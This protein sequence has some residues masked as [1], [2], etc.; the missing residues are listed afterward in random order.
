MS[1]EKVLTKEEAERV[2]AVFFED[3][4]EITLRDGKT[5][6]IPPANLKNA[7]RLM[8]LMGTINIDAII[9]NFSPS[10]DDDSQR[11][12]DLFEVL[13]IAFENYPE[14]DREYLEEYVDLITASKIIE[15]LIG[16]NGLK[17]LKPQQGAG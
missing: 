17:K 12:N 7:R 13:S 16:L 5:Y 15:I 8:K 9:L 3:D 4:E 1:E 2:E 11:E 14:V 6:K 10:G